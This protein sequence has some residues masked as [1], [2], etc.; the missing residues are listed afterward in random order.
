MR[1]TL[2]SKRTNDF[3]NLNQALSKLIVHENTNVRKVV[4]THL[5]EMIQANRELF[6]SMIVN[7]E[8]SS[9]HFLT[10]V[11]DTPSSLGENF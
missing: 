2:R 9:M 7:E 5:T 4:V 3:S 11:H 10:V 1:L 8:L 6:Q